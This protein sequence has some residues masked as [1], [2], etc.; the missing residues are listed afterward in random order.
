MTTPTKVP[1]VPAYREATGAGAW[2]PALA[3]GA[4]TV[5]LGIVLSVWPEATLRVLAVVVAIQL[6]VTGLVSIVGSALSREADSTT[7]VLATLS[8]IVAVLVGLVCLRAPQQT[9]MLLGLVLGLW[10]VFKGLAEIIR[11]VTA[12]TAPSSS[13]GVTFGI[14]LVTGAAGAYVLLN[15]HVTLTILLV[16]VEVWLFAFGFL[17][18]AAALVER[19]DERRTT[20]PVSGPGTTGP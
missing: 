7:R 2:R 10:W 14:G 1:L 4:A 15:P 18:I 9:V 12:T 3:L 19:A 20:G 5:G 17:T 11:A 8:G 13:R 16:V 6:L